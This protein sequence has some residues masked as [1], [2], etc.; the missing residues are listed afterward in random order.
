GK[1]QVRIGADFRH[2]ASLTESNGNARGSFTFTGL[3]SGNGAT[4]L[5]G[6]NADF[7]DFLL[8]LPQLA[9]LQAG[10]NTQ[11]REKAFDAYIDDNWQRAGRLTLSLGLRYEATMP[12]YEA[13]GQMAN[14]DVTPGFTN[15]SVVTPGEVGP[16][17]GT[18]YSSALIN[19][20]LNNFGPRLAAAFRV[21]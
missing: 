19:P 20:D 6:T 9:T 11:L 1:H 13:N 14:L 18:H 10:G 21:K 17:S 4:G 8:G 5:N 15:V 3:Y 16:L 7:A 2:D 12:Y